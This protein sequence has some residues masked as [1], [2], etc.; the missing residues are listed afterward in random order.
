MK[1]IFGTVKESVIERD[2]PWCGSRELQFVEDI[3]DTSIF[4]RC[5]KCWASGPSCGTA[6]GALTKWNNGITNND[7][8]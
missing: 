2:C 3:S 7:G 1:H 4:I 5:K 8:N 6:D